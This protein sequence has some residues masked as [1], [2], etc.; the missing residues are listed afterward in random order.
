MRRLVGQSTLLFMASKAGLGLRP[1]V[2]NRIFGYVYF[3]AGSAG[4]V[5]RLVNAAFPVRALG[6]FGVAFL[7]CSI[8]GICRRGSLGTKCDVRLWRLTAAFK[9]DMIQA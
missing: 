5:T 2:A 4:D 7:A 8:T 9:S 1:L 6:I 3:V